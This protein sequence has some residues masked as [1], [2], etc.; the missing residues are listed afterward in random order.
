MP[1]PRRRPDGLP[2]KRAAD[3]RAQALQP[4]VRDIETAGFVRLKDITEELNRRGA[5][6]LRGGKRWHPSGVARLLTRLRILERG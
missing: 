6:T 5:P 2:T 1:K 3:A 4:T